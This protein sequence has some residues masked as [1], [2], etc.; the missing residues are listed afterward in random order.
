M[1]LSPILFFASF[2]CGIAVHG[3]FPFVR[4][5]PSYIFLAAG[6]GFVCFCFA[7]HD[8]RRL[9][10][11]LLLVLG[12]W[13]FDATIPS[14]AFEQK[15]TEKTVVLQ[16]KVG[17]TLS[18]W[19][20]I[21]GH[22]AVRG[23]SVARGSLV[24]LGCNMKRVP[25]S[26]GFDRRL[27]FARQGI[28]F[29]CMPVSKEVIQPPS[30]WDP[31]PWL[32]HWR[33][34][35]SARIR[36]KFAPD[37]AELLIGMLYGSPSFSPEELDAFRRAGLMHLVAVSGSNISIV[38]TTVFF[39]LLHVRARRRAAFW[40]T[41]I[42]VLVYCAFVGFGASVVRAAVMAWLALYGRD[43]GR[44]VHGP[45]LLLACASFMNF[46][47]PWQLLFDP[48]FVLSF[49]AM[50]GL[51]TFATPFQSLLFWVPARFSLRETLAMTCAAT[52]WTAPYSAYTFGQWSFAGLF[53]NVIAV[54]LVPWVMASGACASVSFDPVIGNT[55]RLSA[56]GFLDTIHFVATFSTRV[57]FLSGTIPFPVGW[58]FLTYGLLGLIAWRLRNLS[59]S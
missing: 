43:R 33:E 48:G 44:L 3:F 22:F 4:T 16:G 25:F 8:R 19:T 55:C 40:M 42:F 10:L 15:V 53:T 7:F 27:W 20:V 56:Q 52:A 2:L 24:R 30:A 34:W 13:R 37:Q 51:M 39:I 47:N 11:W 21:D 41:S 23:L 6:I 38:V 28:W 26:P 12:F 59:T 18:S 50:I 58:M 45:V 57:P 9:I 29:E 32:M 35:F 36:Q 14:P 49:L 1:G 31:M 46:W 5:G 54:P 17:R